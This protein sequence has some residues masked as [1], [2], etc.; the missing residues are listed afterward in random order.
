MKKKLSLLVLAMLT[1]VA[2]AYAADETETKAPVNDA[3][4][5]VTEVQAD[6]HAQDELNLT[7]GVESCDA[8]PT[9]IATDIESLDFDPE[10]KWHCM[11]GQ[12][13]WVP[14][15]Q[16]C[17]NGKK[18]EL[19]QTC[20]NGRWVTTGSACIGLFCSPNCGAQ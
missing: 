8:A 11:N 12:T 4:E 16:C 18:K 7:D 3:M 6:G 19:R 17:C 20:S 5:A 2:T 10:A 13:R 1:V 14:T 9:D 15:S